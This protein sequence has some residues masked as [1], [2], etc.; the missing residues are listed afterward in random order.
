MCVFRERRRERTK[1]NSVYLTDQFFIPTLQQEILEA[2]H[3]EDIP[4]LSAIFLDPDVGILNYLKE[5]SNVFAKDVQAARRRLSTRLLNISNASVKI[6]V[7]QMRGKC[8]ICACSS[9]GASNRIRLK[10]LL[11]DR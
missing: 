10:L 8:A 5:T 7:H 4:A 6:K 2:A 9:S 3:E 11:W 1:T